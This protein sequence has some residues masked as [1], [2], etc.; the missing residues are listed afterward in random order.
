LGLSTSRLFFWLPPDEQD[1]ILEKL[2]ARVA[3]TAG[4]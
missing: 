4:S 1:E 3:R 2:D